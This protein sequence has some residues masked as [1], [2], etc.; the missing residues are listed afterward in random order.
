MELSEAL[1][2]LRN[3]CRK[4]ADSHDRGG[5]SGG[6]YA[7]AARK[8]LAADRAASLISLFRDRFPPVGEYITLTNHLYAAATGSESDLRRACSE[9]LSLVEVRLL[10]GLIDD[11]SEE[12]EDSRPPSSVMN[13]RLLI[14]PA[15]HIK[16]QFGF[17]NTG[18]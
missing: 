11:P 16:C 13:A 18:W 15:P 12:E 7:G 9:H 2:R 4:L 17:N 10:A 14:A 1:I 3:I 5:R 6:D 8:A